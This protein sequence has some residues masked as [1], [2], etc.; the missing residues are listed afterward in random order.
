MAQNEVKANYGKRAIETIKGKIDKYFTYKQSCHYIDAM[1]DIIQAYNSSV[2]HS[3]K[4][5]PAQV[6]MSKLYPERMKN[7]ERMKKKHF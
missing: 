6:T 2:Y 7:E 3:I 1:K 5:A 4:M